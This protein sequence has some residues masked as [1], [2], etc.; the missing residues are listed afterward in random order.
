LFQP[1]ADK[2]IPAIP[3]TLAADIIPQGTQPPEAER[4]PTDVHP[5]S[6]PGNEMK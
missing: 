4:K 3:A 1:A 5:Y 2:S 6:T